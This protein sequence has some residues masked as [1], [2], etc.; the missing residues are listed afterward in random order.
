[1]G[2]EDLEF[3]RQE[4]IDMYFSER[5]ELDDPTKLDDKMRKFFIELIFKNKVVRGSRE[6]LEGLSDADLIMYARMRK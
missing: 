5:R 2:V 1:M 3:S 4:L 6:Q